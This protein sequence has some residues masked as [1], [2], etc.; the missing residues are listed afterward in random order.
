MPYA[1]PRFMPR[2]PGSVLPPQTPCVRG[3]GNR[4]GEAL[5][6]HCAGL[7]VRAE[8]LRRPVPSSLCDEEIWPH[9]PAGGLLVPHAGRSGDTPSDG[10]SSSPRSGVISHS[11]VARS[12]SR[13]R[14][15][16]ASS[17]DN[18]GSSARCRPVVAVATEPGHANLPAAPVGDVHQPSIGERADGVGIGL[19][20]KRIER[21]GQPRCF[22]GQLLHQHG[23]DGLGGFPDQLR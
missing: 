22:V 21:R 7:A 23:N 14:A 6:P 4:G 20:F 15:R 10:G 11:T 19:D 18:V 2:R 5:G 1:T 8:G 16:A 13:P 9:S 17:A 3:S 12:P